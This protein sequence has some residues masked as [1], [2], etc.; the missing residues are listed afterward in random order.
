MTIQLGENDI[1]VNSCNSL[2][3]NES[4]TLDRCCFFKVLVEH[5]LQLKAELE[6]LV[7]VELEVELEVNFFL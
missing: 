4:G 6:M 5:E 7:K 2:F 3:G 1:C